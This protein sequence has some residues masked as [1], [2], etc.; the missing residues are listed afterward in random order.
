MYGEGHRIMRG[1]DLTVGFA[2]ASNLD[3]KA[4]YTFSKRMPLVA[5]VKE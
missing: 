4:T 2:D 3:A 1:M 5:P